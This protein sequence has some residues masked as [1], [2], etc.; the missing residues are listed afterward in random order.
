MPGLPQQPPVC[1]LL[2]LSC[3]SCYSVRFILSTALIML[4]P[5]LVIFSS[6]AESDATFSPFFLLPPPPSCPE[7]LS[8][9]KEPDDPRADPVNSHGSVF[10]IV[11]LPWGICHEVQNHPVLQFS[12]D[13]N[14]LLKASWSRQLVQQAKSE[15]GK[16]PKIQHLRGCSFSGSCKCQLCIHTPLEWVAS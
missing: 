14:F 12:S 5:S 11:T 13:T 3:I 7:L 8:H 2:S 10:H 4:F 6:A 15:P 9:T 16:L 1:P